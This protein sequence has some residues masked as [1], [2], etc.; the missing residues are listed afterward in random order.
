MILRKEQRVKISHLTFALRACGA[1]LFAVSGAFAA[2]GTMSGAGTAAS[3]FQ[4]EDYEDLMAIGTG[5]YLYSSS[6]ALAADI[7]ASSSDFTPIGTS[8]DAAGD[9]VFSGNIDG[10]NYTIKNLHIEK[11]GE[12]D[13]GF[14]VTLSGSIVD[15]RFDSLKVK[16][17]AEH[18]TSNSPSRR[19]GG[20]VAS[21]TGTLENVHVQ[22]GY[23]FGDS[24]IG[25]LAGLVKKPEGNPAGSGIV[26]H[27]SFQGEVWGYSCVGGIAGVSEGLLDSLITDVSIFAEDRNA[28]GIVGYS[29]G[30]VYECRSGGAIIPSDVASINSSVTQV[31][32]SP[33]GGIAGFSADTV[34][35]CAS[36][37][38]FEGVLG[39]DDWDRGKLVGRG[40]GVVGRNEGVVSE[41]YAIGNIFGGSDLGGV[42][43]YNLGKVENSFAWGTVVGDSYL[44]GLVG[45]NDSFEENEGS[46][47]GSYAANLVLGEKKVG[48]LVGFNYWPSSISSSYWSS[49]ISYASSSDGGKMISFDQMKDLSSFEGWDT[50]I[51]SINKGKSFPYLVNNPYPIEK[52]YPIAVPTATAKWQEE[53]V[54]ASLNEVDGT[55][56]GKWTERTWLNGAKD[57]I[58]YEYRIAAVNGSDTV[59]GTVSYMTAINRIEIST[60]EQLKKIG[61]LEYPTIANYVLTDDIDASSSNFEPIKGTFSGEFDGQNHTISNLT[62]DNPGKGKT[63]LF[64]YASEATIK[65]LTFKNAKVTGDYYVGAL[66]GSMINSKVERVVSVNGYIRGLKYV[67]GLVGAVGIEDYQKDRMEL[68][69]VANTGTVWGIED[70]GG[71][72]GYLNGCVTNAFSVSVIKGYEDV[73]GI[74]GTVTSSGCG[75][76]Y[77][78]VMHAYSASII[79]S[80]KPSGI[81]GTVSSSIGYYPRYQYMTDVYFD[82]TLT[83]DIHEEEGRPTVKMLSKSTY[84][85]FDFDSV[86]VILEGMSYP[87]FPDMDP[88]YPGKLVDDGTVNKLSGFGTE[89]YPYLIS[90]YEELKY[91]GKYEYATNLHYEVT[92]DIDASASAKENCNSSGKECKGFE[93]IA[94]F[95]GIFRGN[96]KIISN[97]LIARPGEDSVGLFRALDTTAQVT[98]VALSSVN[99]RGKNYVGGLAGVAPG[100]D[101]DSIYV[102]GDIYGK[103]YVGSIVGYKASGR[104]SENAARGTVTGEDFVGGLVGYLDSSKVWN[105]YAV[106]LVL[107][108]KYVG[109]LA[110]Y[111]NGMDIRASYAAGRVD[112][113]SDWGGIVGDWSD[114]VYFGSV[115]Y[116]SS[117]WHLDS[118]AGEGARSTTEMI[119]RSTFGTWNFDK[120]WYM[121]P[122]STYPYLS[123]AWWE[124]VAPALE[125][126]VS[127]LRMAGSGTEDDPFLVKTYADLKSI[128]RGKFSLSA[129]YSLV[130]DID[131]SASKTDNADHRAYR[132]FEPIGNLELDSTS[133]L[134]G[135]L[136]ERDASGAFTGKFHGNGHVI[137][138]LYM[139][140]V[141]SDSARRGSAL[142]AKIGPEG[143]VD[144][145]SLIA[146]ASGKSVAGIAVENNGSITKSKVDIAVKHGTESDNAIAGGIV[147][148]NGVEGVISDCQAKVN[149]EADSI[150]GGIAAVN[151]G[152]VVKT[153]VSGTIVEKTLS[154]T[155]VGGAFGENRNGLVDGVGSFVNL[156]GD[157]YIGGFVG[158]NYVFGDIVHSYATGEVWSS[159]DNTISLGAFV[160]QNKGK[161]S[162]SFATGDVYNG[163]TF[164]AN[165]W[166]DIDDCYATGNAYSSEKWKGTAGFVHHTDAKMHVRGYFTGTGI[167]ADGS[168]Y[169]ILQVNIGAK[170]TEVYFLRE[171]CNSDPE[172]PALSDSA[173][174]QQKSF[175]KFD[176]DS[177]WTIKNGKTYPMLRGMTNAPVAGNVVMN[178]KNNESLTKKVQSAMKDAV[179]DMGASETVVKLDAVSAEI[180]DS[181]SKAKSP[182]GEFTLTYRVGTLVGSDTLWGNNAYIDLMVD[183]KPV[184]VAK[185]RVY[186]NSFGVSLQGAHV[187]VRFEIPVPGSVKFA[188]LD[189]QGRV[190]K[191]SDFGNRGVGAYFETLSTEGIARGSY[192]GA[193]QVNGRVVEQKVLNIR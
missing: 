177:V 87:F 12:N 97:L 144:N 135:S 104:L 85:G 64:Q 46:V 96:R 67:G 94:K 92:E 11:K 108:D 114:S 167:N 51:W 102:Q 58:C 9:T 49:D 44:G 156:S 126:D 110:G 136:G 185:S 23:V 32:L 151:Y 122:D 56:I 24:A 33:A 117:L 171:S 193:L 52:R 115:F 142:I 1:M 45:H 124:K 138:N 107:G 116:D 27:S 10:K 61:T 169:C 60:Y 29:T 81:I 2:G 183:Y 13:L 55:L 39:T 41:S 163:F 34:S 111:S 71:V 106:D 149:I 78:E 179:V 153:T 178:L 30:K 82:S 173:M 112:A 101:L 70:V 73:G 40:G 180:L 26:R 17:S 186:G 57:S 170:N 91:V 152:N 172:G 31:L 139:E 129:V 128:G 140:F 89:D 145:L 88:V 37:M 59:W 19:V 157:K 132:G 161:I 90:S 184:A 43:G 47:T 48:G 125:S 187:A 38:D 146:T 155:A 77:E 8:K 168:T 28:G 95:S 174:R 63:G 25:G 75:T 191:F 158:Y 80:S 150:A 159:V 72:V 131:A 98:A 176:F 79:K 189:M 118:T 123:W 99:I 74:V 68:D 165:N 22:N 35:R 119:S 7:D 143:V 190:V 16:G 141:S 36:N 105:S 93:P 100:I 83:V 103:N 14:V 162:R 65:N 15:L 4:V 84:E 160:S 54:V 130:N 5:D 133:L 121:E 50:G 192:V 120:V 181:L 113:E 166:S 3:P 66:A 76:D 134:Y 20:V 21:L 175:T 164:A 147:V 127:M 42:V 148:Y 62:I 69:V 86:W 18:Y 109:G 154:G 53:P 182:S 6:Y 137:K 188:L